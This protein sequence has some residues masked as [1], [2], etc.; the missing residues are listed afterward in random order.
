MPT[1]TI[2]YSTDA[3]RLQYERLIAYTREM[4]RLGATAAPGT[5]LETCERLAL[6]RGRRWRRTRA[7]QGVNV[8]KRP[9]YGF[10]TCSECATTA[11]PWDG[12]ARASPLRTLPS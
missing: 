2:E 12:R 7:R 9:W 4:M 5:V 3:E 6:D 1:P 8:A 11:T 10:T